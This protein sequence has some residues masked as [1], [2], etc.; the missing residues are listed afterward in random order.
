MRGSIRLGQSPSGVRFVVALGDDDNW[1][2][3]QLGRSD[4]IDPVDGDRTGDS[5]RV[6]FGGLPYDLWYRD[7]VSLSSKEKAKK[8]KKNINAM[9]A[10]MI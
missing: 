3:C 5:W 7:D 2:E 1:Y 6:T 9:L 8:K 10:I 4:A